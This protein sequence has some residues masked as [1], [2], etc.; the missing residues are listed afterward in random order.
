MP[1][2]GDVFADVRDNGRT[3]RISCH[4]DQGIVVVSL[5]QNAL[6]RGSFR[7]AAVDLS[8]F[9]SALTEMTTPLMSDPTPAEPA[10]GPT[11]DEADPD[12]AVA[13]P[14]GREQSEDAAGTANVSRLPC[15]PILRTA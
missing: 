2:V 9:I 11:A 13:A 8:R 6:C 12:A 14:D 7:M 10:G 4:E 1:R 5:W 15:P 3:M